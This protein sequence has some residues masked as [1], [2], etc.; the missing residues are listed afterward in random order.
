M[1]TYA[2]PLYA[3]GVP[4]YSNE[5]GALG[6]V[7]KALAPNPLRDL[8]IQG[9][10]S[11]ARLHQLQGDVI[12]NQ[13]S[14]LADVANNLQTG[15][16]QGVLPGMIR[17]G[18]LQF[19][20]NV[21]KVVP[22]QY[23]FQALD[24]NFTPGP[25]F[26]SRLARVVGGTG[27][28]VANTFYGYNRT[29][30]EIH[31][32]N[33]MESSDRRY[34]DDQQLVGTKYSADSQAGV[35]YDRNRRY[36][37]AEANT[38]A[39]TVLNNAQES[40]DRHYTSDNTLTGTKYTADSK[41]ASDTYKTNINA[42]DPFGMEAAKSGGKPPAPGQMNKAEMDAVQESLKN[43][44][45]PNLS[46]AVTDEITKR[47][48]YY[49]NNGDAETRNNPTASRMRAM[50]DVLP[51]NPDATRPQARVW[52]SYGEVPLPDNLPSLPAPVS[53][54]YGGS[55]AGRVASP[56]AQTIL[57]G[58]PDLSQRLTG[59]QLT[60]RAPVA[61]VVAPAA[62]APVQ[63]VPG[64]GPAAAPAEVDSLLADAKSAIDQHAPREAVIAELRARGVPD[65]AIQAAGI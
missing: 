31:R 37:T 43:N 51:E 40:K 30:D 20:D 34:G 1:P 45:P 48:V 15:N 49:M 3:N 22:S 6:D 19:I 63:P 29:A 42:L 26:D 16:Y 10:A 54:I 2:N 5:V 25:D 12:Q 7:F 41:S 39:Q 8:Q 57:A 35:G 61:Q 18:N 38:L 17:S 33:N 11:N 4:T 24:P 14:G 62:A 32:K 47:T 27:G 56:L 44:L 64:A 60:G 52:G 36:S 28:D 9:Y 46:Q 59:Q 55:P 13:Q 53:N 58:N 50:S 65:Q 23:S 21:A